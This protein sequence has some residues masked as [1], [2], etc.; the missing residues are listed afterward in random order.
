MEP[1][2]TGIVLRRDS[3]L[4]AYRQLVD[5]LRFLIQAGKF[6][7]GEYLPP[8][9]EVAAEVG[10]N[11]NTVNRAYQQLQRDGLIRS[12]PGKGAIVTRP[13][14]SAGPSSGSAAIRSDNKLATP[15]EVRSILAAGV[16]RSLAAGLTPFEISQVVDGIITECQGRSP[17]RKRVGLAVEFAFREA[18]LAEALSRALGAKIAVLAF[19]PGAP[20]D[21]VDVLVTPTWGTVQAASGLEDATPSCC[22]QVL[23][24]RA[25]TERLLGLPRGSRLVIV[26]ADNDVSQ[27]LAN[28][29][30]TL[31]E[32]D[33]MRTVET[34]SSGELEVEQ[35]EILIV[36][37][38]HPALAECQAPNVVIAPAFGPAASDRIRAAL[39]PSA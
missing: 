8:M 21:G 37:C 29:A 11:L 20:S 23:A 26:A 1:A 22:V 39:E 19:P 16:E 31:A 17:A 18:P 10:V 9:R 15:D 3:G 32:P 36:E 33:A 13:E 5:Q 30:S 27:W 2:P 28:L 24:D 38:G 4:P 35:D 25:S 14:T 7:A 34:D 6:R 12:T